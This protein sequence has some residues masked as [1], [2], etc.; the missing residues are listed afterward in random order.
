MRRILLG[1][2]IVEMKKKRTVSIFF[3]KLILKNVK[4]KGKE[5]IIYCQLL[6]DGYIFYLN[7]PGIK[8]DIFIS[9]L[10]TKNLGFGNVT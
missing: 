10:K 4:G 3:K 9:I 8:Y 7:F 2:E 5:T 1:A 6:G